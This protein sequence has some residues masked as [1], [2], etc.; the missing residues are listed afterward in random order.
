[1]EY[2]FGEELLSQLKERI[3]KVRSEIRSCAVAAGREPD[4]I[5]LIGVS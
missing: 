1:M 3:A 5:T 4:E 2:D